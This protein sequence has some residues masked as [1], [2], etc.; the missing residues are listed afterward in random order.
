MKWKTKKI[1]LE[2]AIMAKF[3]DAVIYEVRNDR[4]GKRVLAVIPA[5]DE[6]DDK[7]IVE[8]S[9]DGIAS[10]CRVSERDYREVRWNEEE[11]RPEYIEAKLLIHNETFN[12]QVDVSK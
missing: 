3:P 12:V 2:D 4:F 8:W 5:K 1:S 11:E 10:E 6:Y 7:R 9:E